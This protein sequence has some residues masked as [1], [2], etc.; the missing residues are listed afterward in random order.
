[1]QGKNGGSIR[2]VTVRNYEQG[3]M[4]GDDDEYDWWG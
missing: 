3:R 1:M 2:R 4:E